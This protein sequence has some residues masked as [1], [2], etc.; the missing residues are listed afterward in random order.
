MAFKMKGGSPMKRNFGIGA[1]P[2]KHKMEARKSYHGV[3]GVGR[4]AEVT[5]EQVKA[6]D[7]EYGE[8]HDDFHG[9]AGTK[10][11]KGLA[12]VASKVLEDRKKLTSGFVEGVAKGG[13]R[14]MVP[15]AGSYL[16]RNRKPTDKEVW[17]NNIRDVRDKYDSFESYQEA[18]EK[19]RK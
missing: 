6:H 7:D 16:A 4:V 1:S 17:D 2:A 11:G 5:A 18:A 14:N 12:N 13:T 9:R 15:Q 10:W 3:G 19:Y 8:G